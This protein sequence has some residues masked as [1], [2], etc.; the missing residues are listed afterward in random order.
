MLKKFIAIGAIA[1]TSLFSVSAPASA[2]QGCSTI[3]SAYQTAF[4][5]GNIDAA[6]AIKNTEPTCFDSAKVPEPSFAVAFL[7][8]GAGLA[9]KKRLSMKKA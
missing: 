8:V 5:A 3:I 7:A 6:N 1:G 9:I 2:N 4:N